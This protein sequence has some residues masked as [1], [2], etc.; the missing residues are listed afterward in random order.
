[1]MTF[2][3][4]LPSFIAL[5]LAALLAYGLQFFYF[6]QPAGEMHAAVLAGMLTTWTP[7]L[8]L[9]G[10]VFL[11][12]TIEEAGSLDEIKSGLN[13]VSAHPVAQL[14]IVGWAFSFFIEGI[15]GF[16]TPA[17]LAAPLLVGFGFAPVPVVL[18]CLALN[19][20]PVTFGA[21]GT[22]IWFGF[23]ELNLNPSELAGLRLRAALI[24]TAAALVIPVFA[25]RFLLDWQTI[26]RNLIFIY[27]SIFATMV[28]FVLFS[29]MNS[30]FP[31]VFGGLSGL[32][33]SVLLARNQIGLRDSER[34]QGKISR[35][36]AGSP[37]LF[38]AFFPLGAT[39]LLL[40]VTRIQGLGL[41]AWLT[42]G[43]PWLNFSLAAA[44]TIEVSTSL[45]LKWSGIL[46]TDAVWKHPVLY[47]PSLIPFGLVGLCCFVLFGFKPDQISR[48]WS[49]TLQR[50]I[51]PF[52][53][54]M[55][56]MVFVKLFM[57]GG[58]TAPV[59]ILGKAI[60]DSAGKLWYWASVYLGAL[61]S[62]FAGS[63]TVSNLT[64]GG[65]QYAFAE[66]LNA[67]LTMVLALQAA[68]GAMGNMACIHNIVAVCAVLGLE[69]QEGGILKKIFPLLVLYGLIAGGAA[70]IIERS[71]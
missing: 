13:C 16:G 56:A 17:A 9:W 50:L 19:T 23:G 38:K 29:R 40:A 71:L 24:Q 60:A 55:G 62:F 14:M 6:R 26:R 18:F 7:I 12:K 21:V 2:R 63:A 43:Q 42:E 44:G 10:A 66:R 34:V 20:V 68:G 8:I 32:L 69:K 48:A 37:N 64:F 41:K 33:F 53:A 35:E 4:G 46:G 5:P 59:L 45:V 65:I 57:L 30:E 27:L 67:P 47:V 52:W 36:A 25:L 31:T 49:V 61:G 3:R 1:M 11:F 22:P 15:S 58:E 70:V 54:L 51:K 39:V 28:P